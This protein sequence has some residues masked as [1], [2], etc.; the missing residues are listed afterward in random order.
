MGRKEKMSVEK[1]VGVEDVRQI[2]RKERSKNDSI[3]FVVYI[4]F[5]LYCIYII[6]LESCVCFLFGLFV[7]YFCCSF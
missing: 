4:I 6:F 2:G 3:I 1:Q 5:S 7:K